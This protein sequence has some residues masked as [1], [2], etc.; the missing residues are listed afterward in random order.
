MKILS[1]LKKIEYNST[2]PYSIPINLQ[3]EILLRVKDKVLLSNSDCQ[4]GLCH[5]IVKDIIYP[6]WYKSKEFKDLVR[7]DHDTDIAKRIICIFN[8]ENAINFGNGRDE[9]YWWP[10]QRKLTLSEKTHKYGSNLKKYLEVST[11]YNI[12]P[13][14]K[15]LDWCI[16]TLEDM[17]SDR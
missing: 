9:L 17:E 3:I 11:T 12:E 5:L 13:R 10:I 4:H 14:I 15:F 2:P 7:Y 16:K 8:K 1:Y 6:L